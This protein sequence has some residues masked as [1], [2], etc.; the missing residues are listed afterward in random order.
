VTSVTS[1]PPATGRERV[2]PV[3]HRPVADEHL[4][5]ELAGGFTRGHPAGRPVHRADLVA[6]DVAAELRVE[7]GA[8]GAVEPLGLERLWREPAGIANVGDE[9]PDPLRRSRHRDRHCCVHELTASFIM[10]RD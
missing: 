5:P 4:E 9:I 10:G 8:G 7:G 1:V 3:V 2:V 6:L